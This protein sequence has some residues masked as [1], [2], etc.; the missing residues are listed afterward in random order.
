MA[1]FID[2]EDEGGDARRDD[3]GVIADH[4]PLQMADARSR[5]A[6]EVQTWSNVRDAS[7]NAGVAINAP[8]QPERV[9]NAM[10]E[11]FNCWP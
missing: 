8:R 10:T 3:H 7:Q 1:R 11:A 5:V 9:W 2:L 6:P 4:V